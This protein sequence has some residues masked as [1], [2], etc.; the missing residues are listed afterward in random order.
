MDALLNNPTRL[1]IILSVMAL[2]SLAT[3]VFVFTSVPD[4]ADF[5]N[6]VY[7]NS[8]PARSGSKLVF[9]GTFPLF[10]MVLVGVLAFK[11]IAGRTVTFPHALVSFLGSGAFFLI[12]MYRCIF[13]WQF[14][15]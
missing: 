1:L 11:L 15:H 3:S 2:I 10:Q 7:D 4:A 14:F 5:Y 8:R 6:L 13:A 12:G 9:F